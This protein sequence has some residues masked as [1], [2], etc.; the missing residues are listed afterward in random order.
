MSHPWKRGD[1][2]G[3]P[4]RTASLNLS[5]KE[6]RPVPPML[7]WLAFTPLWLLDT[8]HSTTPQAHR[9]ERTERTMLPRMIDRSS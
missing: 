4:P 9:K 5:L 6:P 3:L 7:S 8:C 2:K 1:A